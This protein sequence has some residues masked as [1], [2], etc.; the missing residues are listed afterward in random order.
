M[1]KWK[2]VLAILLLSVVLAPRASEAGLGE[3][4]WG[5]SGPQ[6][7][8]LGYGCRFHYSDDTNGADKK[9]DGKKKLHSE[10]QAGAPPTAR[11][12]LLVH[13]KL[14]GVSLGAVYFRSTDTDSDTATYKLGEVEMLAIEPAV[15]LT[16]FHRD[17]ENFRL[18]HG[19]GISYDFAFGAHYQAFDKFGFKITVVEAVLWKHLSLGYNWRIYPN[20]FTADEFGKGPRLHFN[21][22][23]EAAKGY[24]IGWIFKSH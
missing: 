8:G 14:L 7:V 24:T 16:Y 9:P 21:R 22:P 4:I 18:Y 15:S 17:D 23:A 6:L 3:V 1:S 13:P 10:C 11:D 20:G 2:S 19:V 12:E 5:L